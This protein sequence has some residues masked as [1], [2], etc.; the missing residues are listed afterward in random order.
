MGL[1]KLASREFQA[2]DTVICIGDVT[3]GGRELQVMAGPCAVESREQALEI[4]KI[5]KK[6]GARIMRGGAYKPR[7]S[8]YSFQGLEEKGLEYLAEAGRAAGLL[9]VSEV[10]DTRSVDLIANYVDILQIGARNMQNFALLREVAK[11]NK[12][13]LLKRGLSAT[14]EEWIMAAEYILAGGNSQVILCERGIRTF[15]TFTRN[16]LDLSAVPVIKQLTHLPVIVDPSH[17]TG[18]WELVNP[19]AKAAIA[20]GA[21]GLIIEVHPQPSEALSDGPQSLKPERYMQL[22]KELEQIALCV[23]R[24]FRTSGVLKKTGTEG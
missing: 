5:V 6:G 2:E 1:Y 10:M 13:V 12:P 23:G 17:G 8:P 3:I 15:E 11:S 21:D 16:T 7:T 14:I 20:A 4:A 19:M 18:R 22:M 9:L 24:N